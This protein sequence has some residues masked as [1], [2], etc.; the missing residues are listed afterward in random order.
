MLS[1][2]VRPPVVGIIWS[3][4][5]DTESPELKDSS[6]WHGWRH[7]LGQD[8]FLGTQGN[9]IQSWLKKSQLGSC[10]WYLGVTKGLR[11]APPHPAHPPCYDG[12][13]CVR[14][15]SAGFHR[16]DARKR[17]LTSHPCGRRRPTPVTL[18]DRRGILHR[19]CARMTL[20][21]PPQ[22][23]VRR[24]PSS[25][26]ADDPFTAWNDGTFVNTSLLHG[27][28]SDD[29]WHFFNSRLKKKTGHP[30][31][32]HIFQLIESRFAS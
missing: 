23:H 2:T 22:V 11:P 14:V 31:Y 9:P 10:K 15:A 7:W 32:M 25:R 29:E 1:K 5:F 6:W 24:W 17:T 16:P 27:P 4:A 30:K 12:C 26:G 19:S 8:C 28:I 13:P 21:E 20:L 3:A 18:C